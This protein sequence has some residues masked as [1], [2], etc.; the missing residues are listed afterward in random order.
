MTGVLGGVLLFVGAF[1]VYL[2]IIKVLAGEGRPLAPE[3]DDALA[4]TVKGVIPCV[5]AAMVVGVMLAAFSR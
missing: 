5:I 3:G 1:A 2:F 4:I